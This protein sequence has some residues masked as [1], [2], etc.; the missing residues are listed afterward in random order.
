MNIGL[1]ISVRNCAQPTSIWPADQVNNLNYIN[2][3]AIYCIDD[4]Y[5]FELFI[6]VFGTSFK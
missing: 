2:F 1:F 5:I 4:F 3:S 6:F